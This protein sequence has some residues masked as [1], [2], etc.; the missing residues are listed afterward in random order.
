MV[1]FSD[2]LCV[3][4]RCKTRSSSR[5]IP[6]KTQWKRFKSEKFH[7]K[8]KEWIQQS[9]SRLNAEREV[10]VFHACSLFHSPISPRKSFTIKYIG[11]IKISNPFFSFHLGDLLLL[12]TYFIVSITFSFNET[13]DSP[14]PIHYG[15]ANRSGMMTFASIPFIVALAGRNN[16]ISFLLGIPYERLRVYHFWCS[17]M[18]LLTTLIHAIGRLKISTVMTWTSTTNRW[19]LTGFIAGCLIFLGSFSFIMKSRYEIFYVFHLVMV[20]IY[21]VGSWY[22]QPENREWLYAA[23]AVWALDRVFRVLR[24]V[25]FNGLLRFKGHS[26]EVKVTKVSEDTVRLEVVRPDFPSWKAGS[27]AFISSIGLHWFPQGEF[28]QESSK[29]VYMNAENIVPPALKHQL[30]LPFLFRKFR[31]SFHYRIYSNQLG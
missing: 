3:S 11:Y 21:I 29:N 22:H 14:P 20:I 9:E 26:S 24:I 30:L 27:H 31:S 16:F 2:W 28:E 8:S 25:A 4:V 18:T 5:A 6:S 15:Y 13:P 19:G 1:L 17:R 10:S 7:R 23:I 12:A